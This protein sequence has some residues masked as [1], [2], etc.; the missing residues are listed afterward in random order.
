MTLTSNNPS[1]MPPVSVKVPERTGSVSFSLP[2]SAVSSAVSST[3]TATFGSISL[4]APLAIHPAFV[5]GL[6]ISPSSVTGGARCVGTVTLNG[7]APDGGWGV[8]LVSNNSNVRTA[9]YVIVPAGASSAT[10]PIATSVVTSTVTA[11]ITADLNA[12]S[13]A[14]QLTVTP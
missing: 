2:T 11:T 12:F 1:A 8:H 5:V 3:I 4:T 13:K 6:S 7:P 9:T 14:A 10:F